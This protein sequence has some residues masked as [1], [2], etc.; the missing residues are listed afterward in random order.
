MPKKDLHEFMSTAR[1]RWT[2]GRS[3]DSED[4]EK[5]EE[6]ARFEAGDQWPE[7][8]RQRRKE[9]NRPCMIENKLPVFV[10]QVVNDGR[11]NKPAIRCTPLD[12][13][14]PETAE[15]FQGRIRYI[16][17]ESDADIAQDE[18][19]RDQVV[20]GRG[21]F[22]VTTEYK[23]G[24]FDQQILIKHFPKTAVVWDPYAKEYDRS[25]ANWCFVSAGVI[26]KDEFE[27]RY[28]K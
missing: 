21:H 28:G 23:P 4:R 26:P 18:A 25:D 24:S 15:F 12:N 8:E 20:S 3:A 2:M 1:E 16:E 10:A 9:S 27:R 13:G 5:A 17:Y 22:R 7:A 14:T 6:D 19:R 11:Q